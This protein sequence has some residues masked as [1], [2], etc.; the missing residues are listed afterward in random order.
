MVT[1]DDIGD[2][3]KKIADAKN[4]SAKAEGA[5]ER[6]VAQLYEE[7]EIEN[8]EDIDDKLR[9]YDKE[10]DKCES[11]INSLLEKLSTYDWDE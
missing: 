8:G 5:K 6:L 10:I 9:E 1:L 11:K 4:K 2:I 3:K 7:F